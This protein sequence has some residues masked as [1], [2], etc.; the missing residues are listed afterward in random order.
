M[1]ESATAGDFIIDSV[2]GVDVSLPVA[3]I[4]GRSFAFIIDWHIRL[5]I[6]LGWFYGGS[7]IARKLSPDGDWM[8]DETNWFAFGV[9]LPA[10][11]I[12]FL[13][14]PVLEVIMRGRTP[15]K[16]LAGLRIATRDGG[17]PGIGA[18]VIR[19][20]FR[21]IDS[22][23]VC[24]CLGL[25]FT[26]FT[27]QHVRIGDLAAGTLLVYD[28]RSTRESLESLPG[29][30]ASKLGPQYVEVIDDLLARW[31]EL[32]PNVRNRLALD[33]LH[34]IDPQAAPDMEIDIRF[35]LKAVLA[36]ANQ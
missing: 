7:F 34:R 10:V 13:Y 25:G 20:V 30:L 23:P 35:R 22:M 18:L 17:I 6:A 26:M 24:Y 21:I 12:Y 4:G 27:A 9:G 14:H 19:N 5:L 29:A 36:Q 15:G 2:T 33:I 31:N 28:R 1:E 8:F 32:D 3:G 11:A 16:R